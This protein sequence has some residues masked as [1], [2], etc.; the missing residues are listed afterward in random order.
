MNI[1]FVS[2][3]DKEE[4]RHIWHYC[5]GD[6]EAYENAFF[7]HVYHTENTIAAYDGTKPI[8]ALQFFP[9]TVYIHS[10]AY[11]GAYI[12][13]ISVMPQYRTMGIASQ[14]VHFA[15]EKL[16][17]TG[18][19]I[20]LLVPFNFEFYKKLGYTAV[21][22]LSEY[23]GKIEDL[24]PFSQKSFEVLPAPLPTGDSWRAL[25]AGRSLYM[26]RTP[27]DAA[28]IEKLCPSSYSFALP[29]NEGYI[30]Y[31]LEND[32]F[33]AE[34]FF[35]KDAAAAA[36]L[37]GFI[38]AHRAH[39]HTFR[40]RTAAD[41]FLRQFLCEKSIAETRYPHAVAHRLSEEVPAFGDLFSSYINML[42]WF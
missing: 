25:L 29:K 13:G 36:K 24:R 22:A 18:V 30:F 39:C 42:G 15:E 31:S 14:L 4:I 17:E 28:E 37:I 6:G 12:G 7:T 32:T 8:G 20:A 40:I 38:Y 27:S 35:C 16:R 10:I 3:E 5:F 1:R 33:F 23:S 26:D 34:E 41:G 11:S 19:K 2:E 21:S 9:K